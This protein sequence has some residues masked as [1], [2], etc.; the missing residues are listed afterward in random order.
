MNDGDDLVRRLFGSPGP[1]SG[2]DGS[3]DVLDAL[4]EGEL[5]GRAAAERYPAAAAHLRACPDC[6][7]DHDGLVA[8]LM[9]ED[10]PG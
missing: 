8:L 9:T 2:C 5:A 3:G 4:V 7:E 6:R 1:D 10:D